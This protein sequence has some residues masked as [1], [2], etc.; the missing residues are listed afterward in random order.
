MRNSIAPYER[1]AANRRPRKL[2]LS[3]KHT[4][5]PEVLETSYLNY[6]KTIPKRPYPTLKDISTCSRPKSRRR[7][8]PSRSSSST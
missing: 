2:S 1:R 3:N 8:R 6:V 5:E 7:N 4:D